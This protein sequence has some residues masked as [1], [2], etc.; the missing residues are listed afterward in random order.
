MCVSIIDFALHPRSEGKNTTE[1][2]TET[3]FFKK[4]TTL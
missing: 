4:Q 3:S 1:I 2:Q